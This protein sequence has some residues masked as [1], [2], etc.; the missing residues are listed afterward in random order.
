[1]KCWTCSIKKPVYTIISIGGFVLFAALF[2]TLKTTDSAQ[3]FTYMLVFQSSIF[4]VYYLYFSH[5][6][7]IL[8]HMKGELNS[9][10]MDQLMVV[11]K[12]YYQEVEN[13]I[14]QQQDFAR[15]SRVHLLTIESLAKAKYE[16]SLKDY[17]SRLLERSELSSTKRF[18]KNSLANEIIT[19]YKDNADAKGIAVSIVIDIPEIVGIDDW[20]IGIILGNALE[21]AIETCGLIK[22]ETELFESKA[23]NIRAKIKAELLVIRIENSCGESQ[24]DDEES[25]ISGNG[26]ISR[27]RFNS[28]KTIVNKHHGSLSIKV[29]NNTFILIA[30]VPAFRLNKQEQVQ[31]PKIIPKTGTIH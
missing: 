17:I 22:P 30:S 20:E 26:P 7:T 24:N 10:N 3:K 16:T 29:R 27:I 18:C 13:R 19:L 25:L 21:N 28:I 6:R 14:R 23:I 4:L 2:G 8:N 1:M 5:F 12:M 11:Q 15:A 31:E 9:K